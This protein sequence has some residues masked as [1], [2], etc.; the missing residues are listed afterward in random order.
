MLAA[1]GQPTLTLV[2]LTL[3]ML[4]NAVLRADNPKGSAGDLRE[5][6]DTVP[7]L[8]QRRSSCAS[9]CPCASQCT[10]EKTSGQRALEP[11]ECEQMAN[12][13]NIAHR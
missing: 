5:I 11:E 13:K 6:V 3:A 9:T 4:M 8:L 12:Q 1:G 10:T 2:A 7:R